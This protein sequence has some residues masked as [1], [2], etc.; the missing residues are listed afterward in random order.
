MERLITI[1]KTYNT[2]FFKNKVLVIFSVVF[3]VVFFMFFSLIFTNYDDVTK[4]PIGLIDHDMS[5]LSQEV[6]A[7][8]RNNPA[9][10][11]VTE[12]LDDAHKKLNSNR[13]EAIF[14]LKTSFQTKIETTDYNDSIEVI[15]LDKSSIG[16]ALGDIIASDVLT[17]LAVYKAANTAANYGEQYGYEGMFD[18]T[19]NI[20][21]SYVNE[22]KFEMTIDSTVQTP[23]AHLKEDLDIS[24]ILKLN[25]TFGFTLVVFSF[26]I[27][28]SN[29]HFID[30]ESLLIIKRLMTAGFT[31]NELYLGQYFS[32]VSCGLLVVFSQVLLMI[33]GLGMFEIKAML[34]V[35]VTLLLHLLFL[36]NLI[37]VLTAFVTDKTKY[38]SFIA[39]FIFFLGLI[40]GAFWSID[41]LGKSIQWVS[42][43][44]PFYWSLK[45]L[46][47]TILN[48]NSTQYLPILVG[49]AI[50]VLCIMMI[51][52]IVY[53]LYI[54]RLRLA[55]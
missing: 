35:A 1:V 30:K 41:F 7:S 27:L 21:L 25:I 31:S 40:G 47:G 3:P 51:S 50:F 49:Y 9:L 20:A 52:T 43:I 42:Y 15:Y 12:D 26:V 18:K 55:K 8:L 23:S 39:P 29:S 22:N 34:I 36:A 54:R 32:I 33:F 2:I 10:K 16:P 11:I 24:K 6:V 37:L 53:H 13:I 45:L 38:Q 46:N 4:I 17:P 28:F 5:E 48:K 19:K 44:S 14:I